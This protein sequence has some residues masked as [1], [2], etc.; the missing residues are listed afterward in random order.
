M[1]ELKLKVKK[2]TENEPTKNSDENHME[3]NDEEHNNFMIT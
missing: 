2:S 3:I 1:I